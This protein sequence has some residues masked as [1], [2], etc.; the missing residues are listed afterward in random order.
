MCA[1]PNLLFG[2]EAPTVGFYACARQ[3]GLRAAVCS[4]ETS[5]SVQVGH[6]ALSKLM[7]I[8]FLRHVLPVFG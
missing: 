7:A 3:P 8:K 6:V 1:V 2:G 4:G 5:V